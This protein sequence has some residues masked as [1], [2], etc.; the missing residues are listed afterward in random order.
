L[1]TDNIQL[2]GLNRQ[3][4]DSNEYSKKDIEGHCHLLQFFA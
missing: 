2:F 1:T 3:L 4:P